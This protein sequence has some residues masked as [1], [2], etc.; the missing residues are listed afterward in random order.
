[1]YFEIHIRVEFIPDS[2]GLVGRDDDPGGGGGVTSE[3]N[4]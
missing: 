4:G 1:L 3:D 2:S